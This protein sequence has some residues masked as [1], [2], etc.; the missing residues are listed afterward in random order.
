[1]YGKPVS[2]EDIGLSS[3]YKPQSVRDL[4]NVLDI[5]N[6]LQICHGSVLS[7]KYTEIKSTFGPQFVES[8]DQWRHSNCTR[9]IINHTTVNKRYIYN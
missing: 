7:S 2:T 5:I 4:E 3:D 8:L 1:M 6:K 9:I